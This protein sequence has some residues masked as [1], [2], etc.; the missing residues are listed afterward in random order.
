MYSYLGRPNVGNVFLDVQQFLPRRFKAAI[1][2]EVTAVAL[3][4]AVILYLIC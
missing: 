4:Q 3:T 2:S 1:P